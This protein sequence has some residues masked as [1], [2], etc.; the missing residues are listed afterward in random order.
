MRAYIIRRVLLII[1]TF[2]LVTLIVFTLVRLVPGTALDLMAEQMVANS[3]AFETIESAKAKITEQMGFDVPMHIQYVR[4]LGNAFQGDLGTSLWSTEDVTEE[5]GRRIPVTFQLGAMAFTVALLIALPIG[6]YSAIRQDT[7]GDYGARTFAI[8]CISLPSFW[9]ATV[10]IVYPSIW[11]EWTP[12]LTYVPFARD[13]LANI[14]QFILPAIIMGMYM[15]G[16]TM[17]MIRTMML[18]VLRQDYIRTAWSKGL[19]E[20]TVIARH[21]LKNALIPVITVVGL[22]VPVLIGG[23]VVLESIFGLPG[24]GLLLLHS[25]HLRDYPYISG[26]NLIIAGI[27]LV[28]NLLVDLTYGYLDPR[29]RYQ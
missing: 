13:P 29:V 16:T 26:I 9:V 21:A 22:Q 23:S 12:P 10:V 4:W 8:L 5:L 14:G 1:P 18:E 28:V 3:G 17:R 27:I 7:P 19:R 20:R 25:I 11:W 24:L 15:S 6:T 2:L